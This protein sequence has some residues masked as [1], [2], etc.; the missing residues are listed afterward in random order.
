MVFSKNISKIVHFFRRSS[1]RSATESR[2][3][4]IF[5]NESLI[6]STLNYVNIRLVFLFLTKCLFENQSS[7]KAR[8]SDL[9]VD[10]TP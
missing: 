6:I 2:E 1:W 5:Q 10:I 3:Y 9:Q 8:F 7:Q 4:K